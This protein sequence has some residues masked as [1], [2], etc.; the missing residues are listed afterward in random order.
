MKDKKKKSIDTRDIP[1]GAP[2]HDMDEYEDYIIIDNNK[3]NN[4]SHDDVPMGAPYHD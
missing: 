1:I 3:D 2:Y 4:D